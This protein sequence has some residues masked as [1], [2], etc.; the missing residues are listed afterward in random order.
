MA[1]QVVPSAAPWRWATDAL[2]NT[3][4]TS[5]ITTANAHAAHGPLANV[6]EQSLVRVGEMRAAVPEP[7]KLAHLRAVGRSTASLAKS[8]LANGAE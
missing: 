7:R 8:T 4:R 5:Q 3:P 1:Y 2:M 6:G